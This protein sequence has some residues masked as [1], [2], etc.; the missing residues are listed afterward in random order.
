MMRYVFQSL[1]PFNPNKV[2]VY[3]FCSV[4]IS[5]PIQYFASSGLHISYDCNIWS[6]SFKRCHVG[7]IVIHLIKFESNKFQSKGVMVQGQRRKIYEINSWDN[8]IN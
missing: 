6:I 2:N 8:P 5:D 3:S 1:F 4:I 7:L